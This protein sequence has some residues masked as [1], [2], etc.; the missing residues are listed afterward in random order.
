MTKFTSLVLTAVA[1]VTCSSCQASP[2]PV[3]IRAAQIGEEASAL[4]FAEL[5]LENAER[6]F[7]NDPSNVVAARE[8]GHWS[9][10]IARIKAL[11]DARAKREAEERNPVK[12]IVIP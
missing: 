1:A 10:E 8:A 5:M 11:S 9:G 3:A 4:K 12:F 2:D 6:D 7:K